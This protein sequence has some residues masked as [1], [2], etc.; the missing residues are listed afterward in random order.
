[1]TIRDEGVIKFQCRHE[2]GPA[3]S[4]DSVD[5]LIDA[6]QSLYKRGLIGVYE[7][8]IGFGNISVRLSLGGELERPQFIVS[9]SQTGHVEQVQ[10]KHF[11]VVDSYSIIENWVECTGPLKASS[12][13]LTHAM[14]YELFPTANAVI[15]VHNAEAWNALQGLVPTTG[16]AVPYG[17]VQMAR[18]IERLLR[19]TDLSTQ[20]ILVMAG[21][22]EGILTFGNDLHEADQIC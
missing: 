4:F 5:A 16:A 3:P 6:R 22:E 14:I 2:V 17:T 7:D 9:A 13:S 21:H 20:K 15:H 10:P 1:M 12:E 18:E 19:E 11:V 8:G